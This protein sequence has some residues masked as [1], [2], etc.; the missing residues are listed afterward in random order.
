MKIPIVFAIFCGLCMYLGDVQQRENHAQRSGLVKPIQQYTTFSR[1]V[2][3]QEP[4][5]MLSGT[6]L[7]ETPDTLGQPPEVLMDMRYIRRLL[8]E[9]L[10]YLPRNE[11]SRLGTITLEYRPPPTPAQELRQQAEDLERQAQ[12]LERA[13]QLRKEVEQAIAYLDT[14]SV[15][16][17]G[18]K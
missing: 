17:G 9:L 14:V 13:E 6:L 10:G 11:S 12:C 1:E 15:L 2:F 7:S 4:I 18:G 16:P 3:A 8:V 5:P